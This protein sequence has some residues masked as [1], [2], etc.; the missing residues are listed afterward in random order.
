MAGEQ[1]IEGVSGE[2][3][4]D[5]TG[6]RRIRTDDSDCCCDCVYI[7]EF[8]PGQVPMP[9]TVSVLCE[10]VADHPDY[11]PDGPF[12][13][14]FR[15]TIDRV[16]YCYFIDENTPTTDDPFDPIV[17]LT[18]KFDT[19]ELCIGGG[20]CWI[21][22][23]CCPPGPP[24]NCPPCG[25]PVPYVPCDFFDTPFDSCFFKFGD[26]VGD[27]VPCWR[28][29]ANTPP[30]TEVPPGGVP[31]TPQVCFESCLLCCE[32]NS[33]DQF[34]GNN[35][36]LQCSGATPPP[37]CDCEDFYAV[38][39]SDIGFCAIPTPPQQAF[40]HDNAPTEN[41]CTGDTLIIEVERGGD[42]CTWEE[43]IDPLIQ[44][45]TEAPGCCNFNCGFAFLGADLRCGTRPCQGSPVGPPDQWIAETG[46]RPIECGT[47]GCGQTCTSSEF[48]ADSITPMLCQCPDEVGIFNECE[49][50]FCVCD[51]PSC[52]IGDAEICWGSCPMIEV[53]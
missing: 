1:N 18:D 2:R 25:T 22:A 21:E 16:D 6:A 33:C 34:C 14:V 10:D 15:V 30:V 8:C 13:I 39:I 37:G 40:C 17:E 31:F 7:P 11:V 42:I 28:A 53:I 3:I 23:S 29:F 52:D 50:G 5:E 48:E 45:T 24:A 47:G 20:E 51:T 44:G 26:S 4:N 49:C 12:T 46:W 35:N 32:C 41:C 9:P 38:V 36:I 19:C 27:Q 43:T